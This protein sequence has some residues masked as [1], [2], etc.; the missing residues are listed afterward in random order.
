MYALAIAHTICASCLMVTVQSCFCT[1]IK[2]GRSLGRSSAC[3]RW[4][5][6]WLKLLLPLVLVVLVLL[7]SMLVLRLA[8]A[9]TT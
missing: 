2:G 3:S 7:H 9:V 1:L 6:Q 4:P 5:G 8:A